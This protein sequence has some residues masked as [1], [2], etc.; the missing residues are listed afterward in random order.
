MNV[1]LSV[2]LAKG[3][4]LLFA[5]TLASTSA[6][7][8]TS[9]PHLDPSGINLQPNYPASALPNHEQG[10]VIVNADVTEKGRVRRVILLQSTGFDDLDRAGVAAILGWRFIPA[11]NDGTPVAGWAKEKLA[12][13]PPDA[14]LST[15]ALPVP[16]PY[17]P[18]EISLT[19]EY[20]KLARQNKAVPCT[21]GTIT[22]KLKFERADYPFNDPSRAGLEV[23]SGSE[24]AEISVTGDNMLMPPQEALGTRLERNGERLSGE[25]FDGILAFGRPLV[26]SLSWSGTGKISAGSSGFGTHRIQM[27]SAPTSFAFFVTSGSAKFLDAQVICWADGVDNDLK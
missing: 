9:P 22:S 17:L 26:I 3:L 20:R 2:K 15:S 18:L 7:A 11:V 6:Q 21:S 24:R 13:A 14:E 10:A 27:S 12:F 5:A 1:R 4:L 8:V 23:S 19:A 16:N 25:S